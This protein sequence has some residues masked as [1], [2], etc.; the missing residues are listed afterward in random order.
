[1]KYPTFT[2]MPVW[3]EAMDLS[4]DIFYLTVSLPKCEDYGLTSQIRRSA[5]SVHANIAEGFGRNTSPDKSR[6]YVMS[7]GSITETQSHLIYGMR[8]KY[9]KEELVNAIFERYN[10]LHHDLNK[11]IK[12]LK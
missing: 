7:N 4:V 9:F 1:M 12:S 3:N 11:L 10:K 6:F 2:D 8:V 5:G